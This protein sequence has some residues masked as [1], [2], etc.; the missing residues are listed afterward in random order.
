MNTVLITGGTRGIGRATAELFF[1]RGWNVAFT[2]VSNSEKA[3]ELEKAFPGMLAVKADVSAPDE[4][5]NAI[6]L[7]VERF[8]KIDVLINNAGISEHK[9]VID[10]SAEDWDR[11]FAVNSKGVFLM[12]KAA[13]PHML[14]RECSIVNVTSMWGITGASMEAHYSA[15]KASV[16]GFTKALAKELGPSGIRVNAVAPGVIDT[17]MNSNLSDEDKNELCDE[18]PLERLGDP[19]EVAKAIYF[20]A[21]EEASFITGQVLS[22]DGGFVI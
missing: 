6:L 13:I 21:G 3:L 20:L 14:N 5:E 2:Y 4:A 15:S 9:L 12:S 7:T 19:I 1:R 10:M 22:V 11:M 17:D 18:T 16:I 8:G